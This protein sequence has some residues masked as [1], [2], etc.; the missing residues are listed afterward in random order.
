MLSIR[1]GAEDLELQERSP[2]EE[3]YDA[4]AAQIYRWLVP[5][6]GRKYSRPIGEVL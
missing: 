1:F 2:P 5:Y 4:I 6:A 3:K